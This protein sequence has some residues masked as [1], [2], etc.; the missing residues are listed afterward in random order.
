MDIDM[1]IM[2]GYDSAE[3]IHSYFLNI[4]GNEYN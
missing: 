4:E 3:A 1:P 2:N